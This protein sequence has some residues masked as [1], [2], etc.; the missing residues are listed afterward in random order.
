MICWNPNPVFYSGAVAWKLEVIQHPEFAAETPLEIYGAYGLGGLPIVPAPVVKV[1][2]LVDGTKVPLEVREASQLILTPH[3][4]R[5]GENDVPVE[6][7]PL[8][9]I[10][11]DPPPSCVMDRDPETHQEQ[12]IFVFGD[13]CV[14]NLGRYTLWFTLLSRDDTI[15][16]GGVH[17]VY[18]NPFEVVPRNRWALNYTTLSARLNRDH[19]YLRIYRGGPHGPANPAEVERDGNG[20]IP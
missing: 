16:L 13:I 7:V 10:A 1:T 17:T 4:V 12:C 18:T 19:P 14:R 5:L 11:F 8:E 6:E 9:G 15:L 2:R 3:I 20:H